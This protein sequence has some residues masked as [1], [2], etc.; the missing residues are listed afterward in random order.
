MNESVPMPPGAMAE[1]FER[2]VKKHYV[3]TSLMFIGPMFIAL[4]VAI[5]VR[6]EILVWVTALTFVGFGSVM[7]VAA[8]FM[9][10][11]APRMQTF[12]AGLRRTRHD[13]P[14]S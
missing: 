13:S 1:T 8:V 12:V 2:M 10:R 9:R 5:A 6:P 7:L 4:G 3:S 11:L 14:S